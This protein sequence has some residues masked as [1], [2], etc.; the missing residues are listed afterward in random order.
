MGNRPNRR[1]KPSLSIHQ[2]QIR[3]FIGLS[4][5]VSTLIVILIFWLLN[6]QSFIPR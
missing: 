4:V 6:R 3:F 1:I 2:K 5:V